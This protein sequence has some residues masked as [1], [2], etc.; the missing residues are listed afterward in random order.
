VKKRAFILLE[1]LIALTLVMLCAFPLI[2]KPLYN[3][4]YEMQALEEMERERL[5]DWTFS[6]IKEQML[7]AAIPWEKLPSHN[8]TTGP[9]S[10]EP[11]AIQVPGRAAKRI[12]RSY[13]LF[14]KGKKVGVKGEVYRMIYVKIVFDPVLPK[15][16][17]TYTYR[18]I[19][20]KLPR[21]S[22]AADILK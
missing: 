6:E 17:K 5:A 1:V 12:E 15:K 18:L 9:F 22:P 7:K 11:A 20:Q 4:R 2:V 10:M 14:G 3:Y 13:T 21:P 19:A 16:E 8:V